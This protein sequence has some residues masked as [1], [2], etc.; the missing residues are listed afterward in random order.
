MQPKTG[1]LMTQKTSSDN[2]KTTGILLILATII[3]LI[4][5]NTPTTHQWYRNITHATTGWEWFHHPINIRFFINEMLM[6]VFFFAIG[7]ELKH[8]FFC[9]DLS[10]RQKA[11][12]PMI[13]AIGG[14]LVP[15]ALYI[16][17]NMNTGGQ[18]RGWAVPTATDIAF[19]IGALS[20][21]QDH[22]PK[23]LKSFLLALAIFDDLGAIIIIALFYSYGL[24]WYGLLLTG[25]TSWL[26][27]VINKRQSTALW[28]YG[29]LGACLWLSLLATG[30]HTTIG[31]VIMAFAVPTEIKGR[32][33]LEHVH[34]AVT[35]YVQYAVL[36]LFAFF[37]AGTVIVWEAQLHPI[38]LG[39]ALGL[40]VGKPVGI[41]AS[42][43][44]AES[45]GLSQRPENAQWTHIIG[46]GF[47]CGI[48]FTMS[49]FIGKLAF[50]KYA[51]VHFLQMVKRSVLFSSVLAGLIG[52][53][54]LHYTKTPEK[55]AKQA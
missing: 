11:S 16:L 8:S 9:G 42:C 25:L 4:C 12:M 23:S 7:L 38:I 21:V 1:I 32:P 33:I 5:A 55:I 41:V 13:G 14:M 6:C 22:V 3:A 54:F 37:N 43:W 10:D 20:L 39:I 45:L 27:S 48:G 50:Y 40:L 26:L 44:I 19:A 28:A 47:L 31:G 17:V 29:I 18:I 2:D 15:A 34:H 35:P 36:P 46:I 30:I 52:I 24:H 49:L 53:G 51:H